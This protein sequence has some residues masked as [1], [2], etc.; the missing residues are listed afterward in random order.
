M[1]AYSVVLSRINPFDEDQ[2]IAELEE[3]RE[4]YPNLFKCIK[5]D[6]ASIFT[7]RA[8]YEAI[9]STGGEGLIVKPKDGRYLHKRGWEYSKIKKFLTR[10]LIVTGFSEP[11]KE[12]TG[13]EIK[14]WPYWIDK[15][16]NTRNIG[17]FYGDKN[18]IPFDRIEKFFEDNLK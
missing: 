17:N 10:D 12:Y 3:N 13:K 9:V 14:K 1:N 2:Y 18:Y 7:P 11:T 4:I 15:R 16:D 8:Y 6:F 5:G